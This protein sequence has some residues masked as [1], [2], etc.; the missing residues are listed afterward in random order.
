MSSQDLLLDES[1][2][3]GESIPVGKLHRPLAEDLKPEPVDAVPGGENSPCI[4]AGTLVVRGTGI[5][6]VHATGIHT[7]MGKIG[8]ALRTIETEQAILQKQIR[9]FV[10]NF[11]IIGAIAGAISVVLFGLLRGSWLEAL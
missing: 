1:L 11:A 9:P 5:A 8:R 6:S 2:L 3:T 10:R 7:E 4:F